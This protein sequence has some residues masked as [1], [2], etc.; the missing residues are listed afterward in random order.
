MKGNFIMCS[1]SIPK[2]TTNTVKQP[3]IATPTIADAT[4]TKASEATR[5]NAKKNANQDIKT[6]A[7]GLGDEAPTKKKSLLGE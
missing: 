4:V 1:P 5:K 3:E 7:R 2:T 6:T